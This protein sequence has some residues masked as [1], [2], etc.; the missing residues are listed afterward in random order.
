LD[1]QIERH[2]G[3]ALETG[4][5]IIFWIAS[6]LPCAAF[7]ASLLFPK[8]ELAEA[9]EHAGPPSSSLP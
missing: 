5:A 7:V 9:A 6:G 2:L 3:A 8:L 4:L 1:P